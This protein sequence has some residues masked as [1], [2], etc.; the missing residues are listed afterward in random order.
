M[1]ILFTNV[2]QADLKIISILFS[3][4]CGELA[5]GKTMSLTDENAKQIPVKLPENSMNIHRVSETAPRKIPAKTPAPGPQKPAPVPAKKD[6]VSIKPAR[7]RV[8]WEIPFPQKLDGKNNP[9]Y[10][11]ALRMCH[12]YKCTYPELIKRGLAT[13]EDPEKPIAKEISTSV[14]DN[15]PLSD[16]APVQSNCSNGHIGK[17]SRVK[18]IKPVPGESPM[19]GEGLVVSVLNDGLMMIRQ[20]DVFH[21]IPQDCLAEA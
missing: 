4:H 14:P 2:T 9:K 8:R 19:P 6:P 15:P 11:K 17:G 5:P 7:V 21:K 1:D 12:S 3:P 18:Q 10:C 20:G 16:P 13:T